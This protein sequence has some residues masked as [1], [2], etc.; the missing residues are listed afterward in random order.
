MKGSAMPH[1]LAGDTP[2]TV[3]APGSLSLVREAII[4]GFWNVAPE[5]ELRFHPPDHS[6]LLARQ[7][8][9]GGAAD[10]FVSAS[11]RYVAELARAGFLPRPQVLAGNRLCLIAR[12]EIAPPIAGIADLGRDGV[13][14]LMPPAENDPLGRYTEILFARAGLAAAMAEKRR[15]GEIKERLTALRGWLESGEVDAAVM[16]VNMAPALAP[17]AMIPLPEELDLHETIA[18]GVGV[19]VRAGRQ[20]PAAEWL[21]EFLL[22]DAGQ[23]ILTESG[24]LPSSVVNPEALTDV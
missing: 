15:R 18:F 19:V 8:E 3:F 24:F 1:E 9:A 14:L 4:A 23:A 12:P 10:V 17:A 7:I 16:Y 5:V 6:G 20:H 11:W 13:K 21:V 2:L 22:S